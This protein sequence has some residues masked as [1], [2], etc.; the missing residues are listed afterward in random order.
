MIRPILAAVL[1]ALSLAAGTEAGEQGA[2]LTVQQVVDRYLAA[3]GGV[4]RWRE[5]TALEITGI[6]AAFSERSEFTLLRQRGDLYRL[7]FTLLRSPAIRARDADGPWG[8]HVLL[9]P[10]AQRLEEDPYKTQFERESLFEP[11][12]LDYRKKGAEVELLGAGEVEGTPTLNLKI[13]LST[14]QEETWFLHAETYLEVAIDSQV[15][16]FT[17]SQKPMGQRMFFEDFREV[18]GLVLPFQVDWEYGARLE[19]MTVEKVVIDPELEPAR[20]SPPGEGGA[21]DQAE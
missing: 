12:L 13:I 19:T 9:Q 4:E 20:F 7:D 6:Y 5:L 16:D 15:S 21:G 1:L 10:E 8:Q 11:V 14:G 18:G 2:A 3:R 17:Q